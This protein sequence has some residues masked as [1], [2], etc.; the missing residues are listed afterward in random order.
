MGDCSE[1]GGDYYNCVPGVF[2]MRLA[3]E[4]GL[5]GLQNASIIGTYDLSCPFGVKTPLCPIGSVHNLN[6]TLVAA[7]A[8]RALLSQMAPAAFPRVA[9]PRVVSVTAAPTGHGYWLVTAVFDEASLVLRGAQNCEACCGRGVGDFDASADTTA[10]V[11]STAPQ[12][13]SGGGVVF[14]VAL[15]KKPVWV[16]YT[17]NQAFPQCA[18]ASAASGLPALPFLAAVAQ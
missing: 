15:A 18:V 11:N 12:Q 8:A 16:R 4:A 1:H 6:K 7:R 9:F 5:A 10:W 14:T 17:A 2:N 13:L 3:Q